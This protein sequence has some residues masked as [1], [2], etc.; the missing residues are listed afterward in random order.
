MKNVCK[1]LFMVLVMTSLVTQFI[2]TAPP[3][4]QAI[5]ASSIS[6]RFMIGVLLFATHFV[7]KLKILTQLTTYYQ[8]FKL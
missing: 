8:H 6:I 3:N 4:H 1:Q 2:V 5:H 7:H